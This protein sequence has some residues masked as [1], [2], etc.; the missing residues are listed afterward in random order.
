MKERTDSQFL[1]MGSL[2]GIGR[3]QYIWQKLAS[4][5]LGKEIVYKLGVG[6]SKE[7]PAEFDTC[8]PWKMMHK[9]I[10][11]DEGAIDF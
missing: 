4:G 6:A 1:W 2:E 11:S 3:N 9:I 10:C 7:I 8:S 5:F